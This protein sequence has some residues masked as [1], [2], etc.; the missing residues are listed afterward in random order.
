MKRRFSAFLDSEDRIRCVVNEKD[1]KTVTEGDEAPGERRPTRWAMLA[2]GVALLGLIATAGW[3]SAGNLE[4][5]R[6]QRT[7][8]LNHIE[9]AR[10][11]VETLESRL[12]LDSV[13]GL[14]GWLGRSDLP[15][16]DRDPDHN[17]DSC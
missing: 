9:R 7:E 15:Q 10:L 6:Q 16:R 1:S 3:R 8:L 4:A 2:V 11:R 17:R 5:A 14:T 13:T 12:V